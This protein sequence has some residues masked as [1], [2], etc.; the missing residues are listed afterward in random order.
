[1]AAAP[2]H[3]TSRSQKT[4]QTV[5]SP[6]HRH[7]GVGDHRKG[8]QQRFH[9][10]R[11]P[12]RV[13]NRDWRSQW[14][15]KPGIELRE[16]WISKTRSNVRRARN[17]S[18]RW[19]ASPG[20]QPRQGPSIIVYT[21]RP[22]AARQTSPGRSSRAWRGRGTPAPRPG[23]TRASSA[24]GT[25]ARTPTASRSAQAA[26]RRSPGRR[27]AE[28][29]DRAPCRS[30]W[31][32]ATVGE[33]VRDD[34]Q[35]GREDQR[36]DTRPSRTAPD[37]RRC[38]A[39]HPL[40]CRWRR[41]A[42]QADQQRRPTAEP[43]AERAGGEHQGGEGQVVAVDDPLQL[44]GRRAQLPAEVGRATLTMVV[45]RLI[46]NAARHTV[47]STASRRRTADTPMSTPEGRC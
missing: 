4:G 11:Q 9:A 30:P 27:D 8:E 3:K 2:T 23:A 15:T 13:R 35:R 26:A 18:S 5:A 45:S 43:V 12:S 14:R 17:S 36:R 46:A 31:P 6:V 42:A 39:A 38:R 1:M 37:Q 41:E 7:G 21:S 29:G 44:P 20:C 47:A 16:Q 28:A 34:R 24:T 10:F 33:G 19:P 32:A 22:T 25:S 40:R